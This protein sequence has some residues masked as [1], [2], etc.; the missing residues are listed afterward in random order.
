[1][2]HKTI[3]LSGLKSIYVSEYILRIVNNFKYFEYLWKQQIVEQFRK[4]AHFWICFESAGLQSGSVC[5]GLPAWKTVYR[6]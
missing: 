5:L 6:F 2:E 4:N 1:M 3:T